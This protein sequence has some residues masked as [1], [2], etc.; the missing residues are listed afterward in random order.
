VGIPTKEELGGAFDALSDVQK[1]R[2]IECCANYHLRDGV[3]NSDGSRGSI[4][5]GYSELRDLIAF[6]ALEM[7]GVQRPTPKDEVSVLDSVRS[8]KLGLVDIRLADM[9]C[10]PPRI[11]LSQ[12]QL[13]RLL[14]PVIWVTN[15]MDTNDVPKEGVVIPY[16]VNCPDSVLGAWHRVLLE[17]WANS[18]FSYY[19]DE[20]SLAGM[21]RGRIEL[22]NVI[23]EGVRCRMQPKDNSG[24]ERDTIYQ[25]GLNLIRSLVGLGLVLW[26]DQIWVNGA[27]IR[28]QRVHQHDH[29]DFGYD[30][31][32]FKALIKRFVLP[33]RS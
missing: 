21:S 3:R 17:F 8:V 30:R 13:I 6:V 9:T 14:E 28:S 7:S 18:Y 23:D 27:P 32:S 29:P 22:D 2:I 26:D 19:P 5:I 16:Y 33:A 1:G 4:R 20:Y 24:A 15:K 31:A 12:A 10:M 11:K 25:M